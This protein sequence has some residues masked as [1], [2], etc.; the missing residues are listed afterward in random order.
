MRNTKLYF[1]GFDLKLN[2]LFIGSLFVLVFG[3]CSGGGGSNGD[4]NSIP[5]AL[6]QT[7]TVAQDSVDNNITLSGN[8]ADGDILT[9]VLETN[10]TN[11][12]LNGTA[13]NLTYTPTTGYSGDD[14]LTFKVNDGTVDSEIATISIVVNPPENQPPTANAGLD[15]NIIENDNVTLDASSS[16]D[17]GTIESYIWNEGT[18]VLSTQI[19]FTKS[20][21]A[22]GTHTITLTVTDNQG[23]THTDE[24]IVTV[25]APANLVPISSN[26]NVTT[27]ENVNLNITL[28][29][30]DGDVTD[31]LTYAVVTY[32]TKGTLNGSGAN[33]IYIPNTD[34]SGTDSFTFKVND[35]T[36]DSNI[37][38]IN[39]TV[40]NVLEAILRTGQRA[41]HT[42]FD[43]GYYQTGAT[44]SYSRDNT[45]NIVTDNTTGLV[46]QDTTP[47]SMNWNEALAYCTNLSLGAFTDW[48]LPNRK[49]LVNLSDYGRYS[50]A[51]DPAFQSTISNNY[52]SSTTYAGDATYAWYVDFRTGVQDGNNKARNDYVR[53]VR[54]GQ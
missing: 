42:D 5:T 10:T 20:D 28:S 33:L 50:S 27:D 53:C 51:I 32:P 18:T 52:W 17:D 11:G 24:V 31:T 46:W 2:S 44:R 7:I 45:N 22:V 54:A 19:S 26:Q 40:N 37:A 8:D 16:T 38:T 13:P 12:T 1:K 36:V 6:T 15:Q 30:S 35:G 39:I 49:E 43:D 21:F 4:A 47:A 34:Y 9:F 3:G 23:A 14:N 25:N 48:R 41:S 29:A